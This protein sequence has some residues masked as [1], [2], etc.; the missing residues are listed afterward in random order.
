MVVEDIIETWLS[1]VISLAIAAL[2]CFIFIAIM[3][4]I[5]GPFIW[6]SIIGVVAL[7][8]TAIY[9][10]YM[11]YVDL[12]INPVERAPAGTNLGAFFERYLIQHETWMYF[13]VAL[14]IITAIMVLVLVALRKRIV[15]AIA[16]IKEGSKAVSAITSTYFFPIF[17]WLCQVAVIA[18]AIIVGLHLASVG[19]QV[20]KV[21][22]M[23][24]TQNCECTVQFND[25]DICIP[26]QFNQYC[27][28]RGTNE[29]CADA[30]CH[31]ITIENPKMIQ[32]FQ[33]ST[34]SSAM[35]F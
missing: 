10:C 4:W 11:R 27:H 30:A 23:N 31:F 22:G 17:P 7:F 20:Y 35:R 25:G 6:C 28:K 18:T 12:Q 19:E 32:Y 16:L 15:I 33:V 13:L 34:M 8:G 26:D 29:P 3:R 2:V 9:F 21:S 24:T 14:S 5:A 1:M